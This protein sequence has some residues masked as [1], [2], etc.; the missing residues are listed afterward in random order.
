MRASP[1]SRFICLVGRTGCEGELGGEGVGGLWWKNWNIPLSLSEREMKAGCCW[2][3]DG[4]QDFLSP[5]GYV[6]CYDC[7]LKIRVEFQLHIF[8]T[9]S[10]WTNDVRSTDFSSLFWRS[11]SMCQIKEPYT[12]HFF[13]FLVFGFWNKVYIFVYGV[14]QSSRLN[15]CGFRVFQHNQKRGSKSSFS[16]M[17]HSLAYAFV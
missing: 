5:G 14:S 4:Y 3:A 16:G 7:E 13:F 2:A 17:K 6:W 10:L 12:P 11:A 1:W 9:R 8:N 15:I